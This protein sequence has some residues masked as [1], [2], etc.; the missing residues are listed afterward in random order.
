MMT[1]KHYAKSKLYMKYHT[2]HVFQQV[3]I[4][5]KLALL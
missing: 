5:K 3:L 4:N 2:E 1:K